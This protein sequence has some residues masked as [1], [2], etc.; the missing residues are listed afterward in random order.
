MASTVTK[1]RLRPPPVAGAPKRKL[2]PPQPQAQP[3]QTSFLPETDYEAAG[4]KIHSV[5]RAFRI[6]FHDLGNERNL[7]P[8]AIAKL[9]KDVDVKQDMLRLKK[10][11]Y[12]KHPAIKRRTT[13]RNNVE[14]LFK[15]KTLPFPEGGVRLLPVHSL[16]DEG[17][18]K[19]VAQFVAELKQAI[20]IHNETVLELQRQW[21]DVLTTS[22]KDLREFHRPEDYPS[23]EEL[24]SMLSI[25]FEPYNLELPEYYKKID[26]A[27]YRR[28]QS[29]LQ[30][31]FEQAAALQ[32]QAIVKAFQDSLA[33]MVESVRGYQD[34]K[35]RSFK[36]SVV[37]NVF[38]ALNDFR[39]KCRGFGIL[40]GSELEREF[41][42]LQRVLTR[43]VRADQLPD[44]I[45]KFPGE[46]KK[47]VDQVEQIH[48]AILSQSQLAPRRALLR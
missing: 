23:A 37:E 13:A 43:D 20:A 24:Q 27:E 42:K 25:E 22:A 33:Q 30:Q 14:R 3:Q 2:R 28:C 47:L 19:E 44:H 48:Q 39:H 29:L 32:E 7:D 17:Q 8:V 45:R 9:T 1:K 21:T 4:Q 26:P 18:A 5:S 12:S 36:D 40:S 16:T 46:G 34:G 41:E 15:A 10:V 38:T 6:R 35:Q 11:L 31:R